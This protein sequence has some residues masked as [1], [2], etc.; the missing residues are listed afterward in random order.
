MNYLKTTLC[1]DDGNDQTDPPEE[2]VEQ[3]T[4]PEIK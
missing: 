4:S 3:M 1:P 2:G